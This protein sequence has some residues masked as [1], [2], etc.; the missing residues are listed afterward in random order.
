MK[1]TYICISLFVKNGHSRY[2]FSEV[3]NVRILRD[4]V[5][6]PVAILTI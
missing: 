2:I 6:S 5:L 4:D 1:F 3:L